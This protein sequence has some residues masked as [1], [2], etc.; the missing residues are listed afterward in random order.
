MAEYSQTALDPTCTHRDRTNTQS[1][2]ARFSS[3]STVYPEGTVRCSRST[4]GPS[5]SCTRTS[6]LRERITLPNPSANTLE[7]SSLT[8]NCLPL[9]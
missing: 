1:T 4:P 6:E 7:I 9:P 3:S 2:R 5:A 8:S